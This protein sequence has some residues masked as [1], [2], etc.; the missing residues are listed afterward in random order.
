[1]IVIYMVVKRGD[2]MRDDVRLLREAIRLM[3][4]EDPRMGQAALGDPDLKRGAGGSSGGSQFY[5]DYEPSMWEKLK[6]KLFGKKSAAMVGKERDD[7][8]RSS[9]QDRAAQIQFGKQFVTPPKVTDLPATSWRDTD[10]PQKL[11]GIFPRELP[12]IESWGA[13]PT[14]TR[15]LA[16]LA[17]I[18]AMWENQSIKKFNDVI[19]N[20]KSETGVEFDNPYVTH[21]PQ[22]FIKDYGEGLIALKNVVKYFIEEVEKEKLRQPG[23][24]RAAEKAAKRRAQEEREAA[25]RARKSQARPHEEPQREEA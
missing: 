13:F 19:K 16:E 23:K 22:Q 17:F 14:R 7:A 8:V 20:F 5:K 25:N 11:S 24:A 12:N 4:E 3:L 9:A 6:S 15:K 1:M 10:F 21:D 18:D 2:C